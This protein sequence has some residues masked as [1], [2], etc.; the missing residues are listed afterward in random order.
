[1]RL[2]LNSTAIEIIARLGYGA[3][4]MVFCLLGG[5]AMIAALSSGQQAIGARSLFSTLRDQPFGRVFLL[6]I[7][8]GFAFFAIWRFVEPGMHRFVKSKA[9]QLAAR[10]GWASSRTSLTVQ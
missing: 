4:G 3:R 2:S 7:A 5:V 10:F 6:M 8:S 9:T 1:M